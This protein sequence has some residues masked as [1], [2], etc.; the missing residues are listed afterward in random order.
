[1]NVNLANPLVLLLIGA[2]LAVIGWVART[3]EQ[4]LSRRIATLEANVVT[5]QTQMAAHDGIQDS[6]NLIFAELRTLSGL[7]YRI[8]GKLN[9][10]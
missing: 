8:A 4:R 6:V 2:V 7:T 5:L 9:I 10:S 3:V 1:M